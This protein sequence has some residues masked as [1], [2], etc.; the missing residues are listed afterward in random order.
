MFQIS[1]DSS[2]VL[3][4]PGL[5]LTM[6]FPSVLCSSLAMPYILQETISN[7]SH[8]D[9][10]AECNNS[11]I[12]PWC[13]FLANLTHRIN[14]YRNVLRELEDTPVDLRGGNALEDEQYC[15]PC[16]ASQGPDNES[17]LVW[18]LRVNKPGCI[19]NNKLDL[20][21]Q[22]DWNH[23]TLQ[24]NWNRCSSKFIR[25]LYSAAL[26]NHILTI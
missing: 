12:E 15:F 23:R 19:G 24:I 2:V 16:G 22:E 11:A 3:S 25:T 10:Y 6:S 20:R 9:W 4:L 26:Y 13:W 21:L 14:L 18:G 7:R 17:T 8:L 1:Y 5:L